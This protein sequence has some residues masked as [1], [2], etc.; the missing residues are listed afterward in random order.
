[1]HSVEAHELK[2]VKVTRRIETVNSSGIPIE[3]EGIS[4]SR[5]MWWFVDEIYLAYERQKEYMGLKTISISPRPH[6]CAACMFLPRDSVWFRLEVRVGG[7]REAPHLDFVVKFLHFGFQLVLLLLYCVAAWLADRRWLRDLVRRHDGR[8]YER[9]S[10][11]HLRTQPGTTYEDSIST[12]MAGAFVPWLSF[13]C[14][15]RI[16]KNL[17]SE[18]M[19]AF[20]ADTS[21]CCILLPRHPNTCLLNIPRG[22]PEARLCHLEPMQSI[23]N[24]RK[25][26]NRPR[27]SAEAAFDFSSAILRKGGSR[28]L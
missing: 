24:C 14:S 28:V 20:G 13:E 6:L 4:I 1:V 21:S 10:D 23:L 11:E 9:N 19:R 18:S 25:T 15:E 3:I 27:T 16:Q 2:A 8:L 12:K 22:L 17:A 26:K 7:G 5:E